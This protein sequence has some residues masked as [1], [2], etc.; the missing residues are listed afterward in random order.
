[1]SI[2][3]AFMVALILAAAS[4]AVAQKAPGVTDTEVVIGLTTPLSG[5]AA[6]WSATALGSEAWAKHL[7]EQGG[8]AG[9]KIRVVMKD[10]GYNP[11]RAV[12]NVN[13]FKDSVFAI[14]GLLGD[15]V[16]GTY[17]LTKAADM[18]FVRNLANEF[19]S[20]GITA[21]CIA[22]GTFK[23]EMARSRRPCISTYRS[24]I[25]LSATNETPWPDSCAAPSSC[26]HSIVITDDTP[27]AR[28]CLAI[29]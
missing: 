17:G 11:A 27:S 24:W 13:E 3:L 26:S 5:P 23:T 28:R 10:D 29:A 2:R 15:P 8:V 22:P 21:N 12:A 14:V 19:A 4:P 9:R 7:N 6:A 18:Q 25:R 16:T 1:M 20:K